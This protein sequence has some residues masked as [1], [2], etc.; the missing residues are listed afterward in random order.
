MK[1][2]HLIEYIIRNIFLE[3]SYSKHGGETSPRPCPKTFKLIISLDQWS[4]ALSS[5]FL[6]YG[7]LRTIEIY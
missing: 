5:L 7:N 1:F 3:I 2:S 6:L 4:K